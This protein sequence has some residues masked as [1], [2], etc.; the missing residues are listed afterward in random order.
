MENFNEIDVFRDGVLED[1]RA[2][3]D[4]YD[5]QVQV[6]SK[7]LLAEVKGVRAARGN[8]RM[9]EREFTCAEDYK[10]EYGLVVVSNLE[11]VPKMTTI[12]APT[13]NLLLEKIITNQ[14]QIAYHSGAH[15]W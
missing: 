4:G 10:T 6:G 2:F 14:P 13:Q 9:T 11:T 7:F 8:I 1:A 5:F 3:G 12:F 15:T